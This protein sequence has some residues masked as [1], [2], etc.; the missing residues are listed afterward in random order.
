LNVQATAVL[1][2]YEKRIEAL[3]HQGANPMH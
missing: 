1:R 3:E 2:S